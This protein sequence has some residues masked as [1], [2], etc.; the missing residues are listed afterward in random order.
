MMKHPRY[1]KN[2]V[3]Q[4]IAMS[5]KGFPVMMLLTLPWFEGEVL[6][7]SKLYDNV[8]EYGWAWFFLSIPM[9]VHFLIRSRLT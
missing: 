9:C 7:Y 8:D 4:E 3:R 1:L 5:L 2:Q 6:G